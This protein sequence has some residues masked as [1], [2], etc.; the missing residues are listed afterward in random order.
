MDFSLWESNMTLTWSIATRCLQSCWY[1][2]WLFCCIKHHSID[3][4]CFSVGLPVSCICLVSQGSV[5]GPRLFI[6]YT[7]D[8]SDVVAAHDVNL[9]SYADDSHLYLQCHR[10]DMTTAVGRLE[11]CIMNVS[12]WMA[13]N[14]LELNANKTELLWT[15]SNY[16]SASLGSS[17]PPI[18]LGDEIITASNHVRLLGVTISSDL[19]PEKHT[20][21]I[22]SSCF[23]WLCQLWR[24][25]RS[26]DI[27]SAFITSI[28]VMPCWPSPQRTLLTGFIA[29]W[30]R[31]LVSSLAP[32]RSTAAWRA[33]FTVNYTGWTSLN[34]SSINCESWSTGAY[35]A[36]RHSTWSTAAFLHQTLPV[37]NVSDLPLAISWSYHV[38]VVVGSEAGHSS[39]QVR[40]TGT[41]CLIT[42]MTH[43]SASDLIDR[44]WKHS[45]L[46]CTGTH[47]TVEALCAMRYTNQQSSHYHRQTTPQFT[48]S[49]GR[50]WLCLPR[51]APGQSLSPYPFTSPPSTLSFSI[52]YFFLF[53]RIFCVD[54]IV[55]LKCPSVRT[56]VCPFVHLSVHKKF[57][58]FKCNL[59]CR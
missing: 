43:R 39:W 54:L 44:H 22:V 50:S 59:A 14:R 32:K 2:Y 40:W 7:V 46:Q 34:E 56:S 41:C 24:V 25:R 35:K 6:L 36:W 29:W 52:F 12:H 5:L 27:E 58:Q 3:F 51:V 38:I 11:A 47:S 9:H 26:L 42:S 37:I 10:Q 19:N 18:Q 48:P 49:H 8:L 16:G 20:S 23:Y 21:V 1:H 4:Q 13:A 30:M 31:Q 28:V 55:G 33:C 15:G 53:G 17:G 57:L 45:F